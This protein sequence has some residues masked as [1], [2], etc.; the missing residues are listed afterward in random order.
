MM[1]RSER[2]VLTAVASAGAVGVSTRRL[3]ELLDL[4]SSEVYRVV[5][6]LRSRAV[7]V[8]LRHGGP[9]VTAEFARP[10]GWGGPRPG[11]RRGAAG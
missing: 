11:L 3:V 8:R 7:L 10:E 9:L 1:S 6:V 2:A 4:S 5:A